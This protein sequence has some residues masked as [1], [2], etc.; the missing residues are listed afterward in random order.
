MYVIARARVAE[1]SFVIRDLIGR[2]S[3]KYVLRITRLLG[4]HRL[5]GFATA[6]GILQDQKFVCSKDK[7]SPLY[8]V[9]MDSK[10]V[11]ARVRCAPCRAGSQY[12]V[13]GLNL[14]SPAVDCMIRWEL[15][16][17]SAKK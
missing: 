8:S 4:N 14:L 11:C 15:R 5:G 2:L 13:D 1:D 7:W 9:H 17:K 6:V 3:D 16:G 12:H 10:A